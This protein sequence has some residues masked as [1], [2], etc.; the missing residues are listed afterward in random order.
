MFLIHFT[1]VY[2][3][4]FIIILF[5]IFFGVLKYSGG[6][7]ARGF[8]GRM[9]RHYKLTE[10]LCRLTAGF[11]EREESTNIDFKADVPRYEDEEE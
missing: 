1:F 10:E 9:P 4:Y 11:S 3:Y 6:F 5:F 2:Y 8:Q 7:H